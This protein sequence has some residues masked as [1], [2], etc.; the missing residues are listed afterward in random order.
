MILVW[1]CS[2]F[3]F[4]QWYSEMERL[5]WW[6]QPELPSLI[7]LS[8]WSEKSFEERE[9]LSNQKR[10]RDKVCWLMTIW[11]IQ[12]GFTALLPLHFLAFQNCFSLHVCSRE[13]HQFSLGFPI[14]RLWSWCIDDGQ[15]PRDHFLP[16]SSLSHVISWS[17]WLLN[18]ERWRLFAEINNKPWPSRHKTHSSMTLLSDFRDKQLLCSLSSNSSDLLVSVSSGGHV[19]W[20]PDSIIIVASASQLSAGHGSVK[21][22]LCLSLL[23]E[24][25]CCLLLPH[26]DLTY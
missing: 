3:D 4:L 9:V 26:R 23:P 5:V 11:P 21:L 8:A 17:I 19:S 6:T 12:V 2:S 15:S 13:M 10:E 1:C 14:D 22:P 18:Q 16:L 25:I 7:K 20:C 24:P